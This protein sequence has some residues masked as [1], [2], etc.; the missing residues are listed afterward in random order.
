[1]V[2]A[3]RASGALDEL[4][5]RIDSGEVELTGADGL[6]PALLKDSQGRGLAADDLP[7]GLREGRAD[8]GSAW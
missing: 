8:P 3:L 5:S 2:V 7:P 4:F 1:M 6:M